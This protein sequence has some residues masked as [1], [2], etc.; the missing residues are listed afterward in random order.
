M[1][2]LS[3]HFD[4]K[5]G[6]VS[7]RMR[8]RWVSQISVPFVI[9]ISVQCCRKVVGFQILSHSHLECRSE[10]LGGVVAKIRTPHPNYQKVIFGIKTCL[11]DFLGVKNEHL[12]R[13]RH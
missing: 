2:L 7:N 6:R 13:L 1:A 11:R 10:K 12:V 9:E 4:W 5:I 3:I 8:V